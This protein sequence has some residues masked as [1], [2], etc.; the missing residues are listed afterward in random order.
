[1]QQ[2]IAVVMGKSF[3]FLLRVFFFV[4]RVCFLLF[5]VRVFVVRS[6]MHAKHAQACFFLAMH[7]WRSLRVKITAFLNNV[8]FHSFFRRTCEVFCKKAVQPMLFRQT[9]IFL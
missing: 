6:A 4:L 1:M 7:A 3:V 5:V 9:S 2:R 8:D